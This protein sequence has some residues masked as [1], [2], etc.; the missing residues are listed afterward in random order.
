MCVC[1]LR[2]SQLNPR[3]SSRFVQRRSFV[4]P[5]MGVPKYS[6]YST[7]RKPERG[8]PVNVYSRIAD[9]L[10][11]SPSVARLSRS[12]CPSI[13][14]FTPRSPLPPL[15]SLLSRLLVSARIATVR[16]LDLVLPTE[17]FTPWTSLV[18]DRTARIVPGP[19]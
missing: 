13:Y 7:R 4:S 9:A 3:N 15:C 17:H 5:I 10:P 8:T 11:F 1:F 12:H 19:G 2:T 18:P 14:L 6:T 16:L